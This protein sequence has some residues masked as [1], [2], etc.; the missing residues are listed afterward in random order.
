MLKRYGGVDNKKTLGEI[1]EAILSDTPKSKETIYTKTSVVGRVL[2]VLITYSLTELFLIA[3]G[4]YEKTPSWLFFLLPLTPTILWV[5]ARAQNS[6]KA[7][8][9][10]L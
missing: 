6:R 9:A 7:K 1:Q 5:I 4:V 2:F 3:I 8:R 10:L